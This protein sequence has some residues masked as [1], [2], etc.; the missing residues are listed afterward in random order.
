MT[1]L[2]RSLLAPPRSWGPAAAAELS[3]H[4]RRWAERPLLPP[5][6]TR[7]RRAEVGLAA[8]SVELVS[9]S[10]C[11]RLNL[12]SYPQ[13]S[14]F[15]NLQLNQSSKFFTF[16]SAPARLSRRGGSRPTSARRRRQGL[17]SSAARART[18]R[19]KSFASSDFFSPRSAL[20]SA[21][22]V[23]ERSWSP[24]INDAG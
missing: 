5:P 16:P 7:R 15:F 17:S 6:S 2:G 14:K 13:A 3:A 4:C 12:P 10:I 11:S 1:W 22:D 24:L 8:A 20:S 21:F 9:F 23:N 18:E 19:G